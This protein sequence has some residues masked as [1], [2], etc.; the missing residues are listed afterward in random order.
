M[1]YVYC[2]LGHEYIFT[3][4]YQMAELYYKKALEINN[5][6]FHG[7]WGLGYVHLK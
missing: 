5:T 7:F 6:E 3:E 4:D 2:L 1:S